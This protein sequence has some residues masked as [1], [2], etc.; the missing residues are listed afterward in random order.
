MRRS[1]GR[2][3]Q[4]RRG[5]PPYF[6]CALWL[7]PHFHRKVCVRIAQE[8]RLATRSTHSIPRYVCFSALHLP[9]PFSPSH[10][11]HD[12]ESLWNQE[13]QGSTDRVAYAAP[14]TI[15]ATLLISNGENVKVTQS[16]LRHK[17][18]KSPWN[19]T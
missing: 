10:P 11:S 6:S 18:Q 7:S 16:Q 2:N 4:G 9:D 5:G 12:R 3:S 17:L 1:E 19:S 13:Q 14:L 15:L 8:R